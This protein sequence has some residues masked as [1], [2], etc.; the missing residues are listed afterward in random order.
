MKTEDQ[1][2]GDSVARLRANRR[3]SQADL[4]D[5]MRDHGFRW[6][7]ATVWSVE[8]GDRPLRLT[9]GDALAF[10]LGLESVD[11]LLP[12]GRKAARTIEAA[13]R[14]HD[15]AVTFQEARLELIQSGQSAQGVLLEVDGDD[16]DLGPQTRAMEELAVHVFIEH[17]NQVPGDDWR[18]VLRDN[19][20]TFSIS[21]PKT[22][23]EKKQASPKKMRD[24][25]TTARK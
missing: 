1:R 20:V 2:I 12:R 18:Q 24:T 21:E 5:R 14:V 13:Q 11:M 3:M 7:Q 25:A 16:P 10:V 22:A 17:V 23:S 19:G 4:A 15:A 8:K 9:E 6:S